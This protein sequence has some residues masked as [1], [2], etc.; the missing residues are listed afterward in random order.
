MKEIVYNC[1]T[2]QQNNFTFYA[3]SLS[4]CLDHY[5]DATFRTL[6]HDDATWI[7]DDEDF[8]FEILATV[9]VNTNRKT[10]AILNCNDP[11]LEAD[12]QKQF[13]AYK[14]LKKLRGDKYF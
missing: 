11:Q 7:E 2:G 6:L 8:Q 14:V 12:I 3:D 9:K 10:F 4:K 13:D 5:G 1:C